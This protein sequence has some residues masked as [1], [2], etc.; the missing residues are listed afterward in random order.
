MGQPCINCG[1]TNTT[2]RRTGRCWA[3]YE[4]KRRH[5][6]DIDADDMRRH[7]RRRKFCTN[8]E[9]TLI[10]AKGLCVT[11]YQHK[12][13]LGVT[14]P[15]SRWAESCINCDRPKGEQIFRHGR[16][17][18]CTRWW[19]KYGQERPRHFAKKLAPIGWCDCGKPGKHR[20][21]LT[22][23]RTGTQKATYILC[24]DCHTLEVT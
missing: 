8:C 1:D 16:C 18:A 2:Q 3:C 6:K 21:A 7:R 11:C 5:G 4:Y 9:R 15:Q 22:C 17:Q 14:R 13:L 10:H 24:D 23:G 19:K 20:V 12:R